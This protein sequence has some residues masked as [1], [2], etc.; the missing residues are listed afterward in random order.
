MHKQLIVAGIGT[1]I[2]KTFCSAIL[3]ENLQADYWKPIQSGFPED[4]DVRTIKELTS[5][6][7]IFHPST[8]N[9]KAPLSPHTAAELEG[10][11]IYLNEFELPNTKNSLIVELAGGLL[12]PINDQETNLDLIKKLGLPVVLISKN[13]LGSIN[14]T[15][16]SIELLKQHHVEIEGI[17]FN[18][19]PN[20]SG[21]KFIEN[22]SN[23]PVLCR[24]NQE[25]LTNPATIQKYATSVVW[26]IK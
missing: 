12:V 11:T 16:L 21:E 20:T 10:K 6:E 4:S 5:T 23:L 2:G 26:P 18:G 24:V 22:Y 8:Y 1:E 17:I 19:V 13:Y 15:L 7:A 14:H 9:L 25:E 3:V